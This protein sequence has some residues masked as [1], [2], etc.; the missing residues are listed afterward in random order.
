MINMNEIIEYTVTKQCSISPDQDAKK[1]GISKKIN[2]VIKFNS[3]LINILHKAASGA[4]IQWQN[5]QGRKNYDKF[6]NN[7]KV[8]IMFNAP[9]VAPQQDPMEVLIGEAKALGI[10]LEEHMINEMKR[11]GL[12]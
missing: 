10:S 6:E 5:G 9:A 1:A 4:I 3:Q 2:C 8:I 12:K 7:Q 11:R